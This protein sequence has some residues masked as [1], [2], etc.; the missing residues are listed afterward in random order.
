MTE[1]EKLYELAGVE[2]KVM[3][4]WTCK[5]SETCSLNCEHYG[6]VQL[7]YPPFTAE[8]Q[9]ELLAF[10]GLRYGFEMIDNEAMDFMLSTTMF[11]NKKLNCTGYG[12]GFDEAIAN[13]TNNLWEWLPEDYKKQIREILK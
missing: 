3:C 5:G 8:K 1:V 10:I 9:I 6:S 13:L 11:S 4:E 12:Y 7:Y 2:K